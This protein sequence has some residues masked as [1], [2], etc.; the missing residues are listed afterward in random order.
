MNRISPIHLAWQDVRRSLNALAETRLARAAHLNA[1]VVRKID[2]AI[3]ALDDADEAINKQ[4]CE[5]GA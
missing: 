5:G 1:E 4:L 2:A 3:A